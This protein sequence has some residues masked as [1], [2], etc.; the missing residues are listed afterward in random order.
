MQFDTLYQ[1]SDSQERGRLL[2]DFLNRFFALIRIR[3]VGSFRRNEGGEQ[4]DGAFLWDGW[5]YLVECKWQKKLS[6]IRELDS[7]SG[8]IGR[9]GKATQ[10]MFLS[11]NGWSEHVP[12]LLKQNIEKNIILADGYD[13]RLPLEAELSCVRAAPSAARR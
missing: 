3:S 12:G 5:H 2:E 7:L 4:I 11:I 9:G 1:M 10:G 6:D 13:L 8:K